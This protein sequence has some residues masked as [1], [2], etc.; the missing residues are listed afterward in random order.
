MLQGVPEASQLFEM[1]FP[2]YWEWLTFSVDSLKGDDM[3][4]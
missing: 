4:V 1:M 3:Y 2:V